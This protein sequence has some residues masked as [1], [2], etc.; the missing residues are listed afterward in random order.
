MH[1]QSA[2]PDE[3]ATPDAEAPNAPALAAPPPPI[4]AAS[5][6]LGPRADWHPNASLLFLAFVAIV[7][8][9]ALGYL[10]RGLHPIVG[11]AIGVVL[12]AFLAL[13]PST[14]ITIG[15]DG[16]AIGRRFL[17]WREVAAVRPGEHFGR[18][19]VEIVFLLK[20]GE[21]FALHCMASMR[22]EILARA[23]AAQARLHREAPGAEPARAG[24]LLESSL[25]RG[26][27]GRGERDEG[28]RPALD[29][30]RQLRA[31]G[32]GGRLDHRTAPVDRDELWR[33]ALD[34]EREP[35]LRAAAATALGP[36]LDDEGRQRLRIAAQGTASK[37][38]RVALEAVA[39][40]RDERAVAEALAQVEA[41]KA[42]RTKA[43]PS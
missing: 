43:S 9:V 3:A 7:P 18:G 5:F 23:W 15:A 13:G 30:V 42:P 19:I 31:L 11:I 22:A 4:A 1:G 8:T 29:W 24:G 38:L 39:A 33:A 20:N 6:D 25:R 28:R 21:F 26:G 36:T 12:T 14:T 34:P 40:D 37:K 16:I 10:F 35:T 27:A 17:G 2:E 32:G 41:I